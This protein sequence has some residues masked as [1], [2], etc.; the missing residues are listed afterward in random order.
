MCESRS[1][2]FCLLSSFAMSGGH[3]ALIAAWIAVR[4]QGDVVGLQVAQLHRQAVQGLRPGGAVGE[5][6]L[7]VLA[8]DVGDALVGPRVGEAGDPLVDVVLAHPGGELVHVDVHA[9]AV[10]REAAGGL[11]HEVLDVV[12]RGVAPRD[13]DV[14]VGLADPVRTGGDD[15]R[16]VGLRALGEDV[17]LHAVQ[18]REVARGGP[19]GLVAGQHDA[20]RLQVD[21][22]VVAELRGVLRDLVPVG[23]RGHRQGDAVLD[24]LLDGVLREEPGRDGERGD[25]RAGALGLLLDTDDVHGPGALP[26][27]VAP[28]AHVLVQE[29]GGLPRAGQLAA[30]VL[31]RQALLPLLGEGRVEIV[32]ND[33]HLRALS[34][35]FL[36]AAGRRLA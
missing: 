11:A 26:Q 21:V 17:H 25:V 6:L 9:V 12:E 18:D 23:L 5:Q 13:H 3:D 24:A 14:L 7:D 27:R 1:D 2:R 8:H 32:E 30:E 31:R 36:A 22:G 15:A 35:D 34:D 19:G 20:L 16:A 10:R 4:Q 33:G 29:A 28:G